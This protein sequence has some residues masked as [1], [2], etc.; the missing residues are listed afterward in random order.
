MQDPELVKERRS[1]MT[2]TRATKEADNIPNCPINDIKFVP[3]T[4]IQ[5]QDPDYT[6]IDF[7][8]EP[9]IQLIFSRKAN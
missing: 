1:Q 6:Y 2:Y 8:E 4:S 9:P 7:T 3:K 5:D